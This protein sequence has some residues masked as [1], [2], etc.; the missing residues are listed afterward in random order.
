MRKVLKSRDAS[1]SGSPRAYS[2]FQRSGP[3]LGVPMMKII[4]YEGLFGGPCF[5][6]PPKYMY[7]CIHIH[8]IHIH[9]FIYIYIHHIPRPP[10]V[11][12]LRALWSLLDGIWGSL[13]GSWGVLVYHIYIYVSL[14]SSRV[15][16]ALRVKPKGSFLLCVRAPSAG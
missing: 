9:L 1:Y 7:I 3:S 6:N 16:E 8:N 2:C 4:V 5:S 12:L 11:P 15:L 13:K 14:R 10:N